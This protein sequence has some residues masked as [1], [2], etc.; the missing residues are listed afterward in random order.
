[1]VR[2]FRLFLSRVVVDGE[3][4]VTSPLEHQ[5]HVDT[6]GSGS[7]NTNLVRG[8]RPRDGGEGLSSDCWGRFGGFLK[9]S[10]S[11]LERIYSILASDQG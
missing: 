6:R 1:M 9:S 5:S 11:S 10:Q 3:V 7:D 2:Q 4:G 8:T